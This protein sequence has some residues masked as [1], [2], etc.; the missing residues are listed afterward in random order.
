MLG[1]E[2]QKLYGSVGI[3]PGF[4]SSFLV[5]LQGCPY[6]M[7][8]GGR[9]WLFVYKYMIVRRLRPKERANPPSAQVPP[10]IIRTAYTE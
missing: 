10:H 5:F 7:E 8:R 2:V 9:D 1:G 6:F 3:F 4:D